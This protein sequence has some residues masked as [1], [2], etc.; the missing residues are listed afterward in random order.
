MKRRHPG[1]EEK[2][3][4]SGVLVAYQTTVSHLLI[5][6]KIAFETHLKFLGEGY[7]DVAFQCLRDILWTIMN[8]PKIPYPIH[9]ETVQAA[10]TSKLY[11][12]ILQSVVPLDKLVGNANAVV[13][14]A[15]KG[16]GKGSYSHLVQIAC[17]DIGA[18]GIYVLVLL[19]SL[20]P[21]VVHVS[22][23]VERYI[24]AYGKERTFLFYR[25]NNQMLAGYADIKND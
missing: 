2:V 13:D 24:S 11:P 7:R 14:E 6:I 19:E 5:C 10:I 9:Y 17:L 23:E 18:R 15:R 1:S 4:G 12:S 16:S 20:P 25:E 21:L 8:P 3:E 22:N